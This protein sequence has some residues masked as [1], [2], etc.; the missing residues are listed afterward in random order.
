MMQ[1][2]VPVLECNNVGKPISFYQV[3]LHYDIT[4][5]GMPRQKGA[6][7]RFSA[8]KLLLSQLPTKL[9][10]LLLYW[11]KQPFK[12]VS[13]VNLCRKTGCTESL[14]LSLLYSQKPHLQRHKNQPNNARIKN[15]KNFLSL[16]PSRLSFSPFQGII[17]FKTK[18]CTPAE[19]AP[20]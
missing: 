5:P 1:V 20:K 13:E 8:G 3:R 16:F 11:E 14:F 2:T 12:E 7:L 19:E 10:S 6:G 18:Q 15:A 17:T 9:G 4:M